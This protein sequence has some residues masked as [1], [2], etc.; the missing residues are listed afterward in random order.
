MASKSASS[1]RFGHAT[2]IPYPALDETLQQVNKAAET[3]FLAQPIPVKNLERVIELPGYRE[4][5]DIN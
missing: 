3:Y 5:P 4:W 2:S 1:A